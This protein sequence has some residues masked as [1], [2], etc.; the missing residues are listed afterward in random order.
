MRHA[1]AIGL[2]FGLWGGVWS[3]VWLAGLYFF[4]SETPA[5]FGG[6]VGCVAGSFV[7]Q[8]LLGSAA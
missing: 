3:A 6:F 5:L 1:L 7:A 8:H 4:Q 2:F